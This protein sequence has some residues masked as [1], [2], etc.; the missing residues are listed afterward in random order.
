MPISSLV[1]IVIVI[2]L[3]GTLLYFFFIKEGETPQA[4]DVLENSGA[5]VAEQFEDQTPV[6]PATIISE[7]QAVEVLPEFSLIVDTP[8][9]GATLDGDSLVFYDGWDSQLVTTNLQGG[10]LENESVSYPSLTE[11][12]WAPDKSGLVW[13]EEGG[14]YYY[15]DRD[16]AEKVLLGPNISSPVFNR[17]GNLWYRFI[18]PDGTESGIRIGSP[19]TGLVDA[20]EIMP[21]KSNLVLKSIPG[22]EEISYYLTPSAV[23]PAGMYTLDT[24]GSK[25]PIVGKDTG[26]EISWSPIADQLLFTRV[27]N[28]S[29][30]ELWRTDSGGGNSQKLKKSTLI[31]KIAWSPDGNRIWL[32]IPKLIPIFSDYKDGISLTE[33]KLYELDLASNEVREL[34]DLS[35]QGDKIDARDM[36]LS[37]QGKIL[38]LRNEHNNSLYA[39]NLSKL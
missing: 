19:R 21:A 13:R 23:R 32:A 27:K 25:K 5:T 6:E 38:Y 9:T 26:V 39:V 29:Q 22:Q 33:D 12:V 34:Y 31:D 3:A 14:E 10:K 30:M 11:I 15:S 7:E 28:G 36:F 20:Q 17:D 24:G 16:V 18:D 4:V 37:K 1:F 2:L 8:V 35:G